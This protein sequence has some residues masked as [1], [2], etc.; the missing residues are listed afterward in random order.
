MY[1]KRDQHRNIYD[2][3]N[4]E[5]ASTKIKS[6]KLENASNTY[7]LFNSV[8]FNTDDA[9]DK[10]LLYNQIVAWHCKG[11]SIAPLSDCAHDPIFQELL[12]QSKYFTSAGE[13]FLIDLR[14]GKGYTNEIEKL[15]GGDSDLLVTI[16]LRNAAA[17]K[18]RLY[19]TRYYQGE[20]L[21]L[22]S[23]NGL[24]INYKEYGVNK[25]KSTIS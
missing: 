6:I 12:T 21:Y 8:K 3:Y 7:S 22:L 10:F 25:Q 14:P 24:I 17:K 18:M 11:S 13:K 2:S 5:L 16:T 4:A 15:N 9:H 23:N 19:V 1:D 20:N